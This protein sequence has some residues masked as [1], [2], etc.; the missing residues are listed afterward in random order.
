MIFSYINVSRLLDKIYTGELYL[1]SCSVS[2]T[3]L[4]ISL[5]TQE[6]LLMFL[7]LYHLHEHPAKKLKLQ[8]CLNSSQRKGKNNKLYFFIDDSLPLTEK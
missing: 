3:A 1:T 8:S 7:I 4:Q 6:P 5:P 2:H